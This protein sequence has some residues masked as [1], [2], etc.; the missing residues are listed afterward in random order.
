MAGQALVVELAGVR[1][2][3]FLLSVAAVRAG[4][5]GF[6]D[7]GAHLGIT[8]VRWTDSLHPLWPLSAP[9]AELYRRHR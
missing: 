8:S 3:G 7:D 6:E 9:P 5:H 2:H 4:Q 1:G